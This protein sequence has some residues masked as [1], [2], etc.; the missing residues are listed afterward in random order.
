[1]LTDAMTNFIHYLIPIS[2]SYHNSNHS[3]TPSLLF[4]LIL[5][6]DNN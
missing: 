2:K 5:T 6:P 4:F 3:L 1:M